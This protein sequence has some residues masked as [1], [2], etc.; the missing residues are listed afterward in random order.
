MRSRCARVTSTEL[1]VLL[2]RASAR[3]A[4]VARVRSGGR[5]VTSV[6]SVRSCDRRSCG[7]SR[8]GGEPCRVL[9]DAAYVGFVGGSVLVEDAG[10]REALLLGLRR[11]GEHGLGAEARAHD[12][13]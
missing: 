9:G 6:P 7:V 8:T 4:A 5:S 13:G 11:A 10:H 12:V 3:A 2:A 1:I